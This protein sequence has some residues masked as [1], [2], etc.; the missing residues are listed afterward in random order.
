[1]ATTNHIVPVSAG[2]PH[3]WDN[4]QLACMRCNS[5]KSDKVAG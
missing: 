1:M 2:G 5:V 4:V 3:T